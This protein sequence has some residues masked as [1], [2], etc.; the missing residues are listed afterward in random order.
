MKFDELTHF[1]HVVEIIDKAT[2]QI[3]RLKRALAR[4]HDYGK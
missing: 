3:T 2:T 1:L 4:A